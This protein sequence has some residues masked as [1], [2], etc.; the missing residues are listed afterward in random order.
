[1]QKSLENGLSDNKREMDQSFD[2]AL[3]KIEQFVD[4]A[5]CVRVLEKGFNDNRDEMESLFERV[6]RK[7]EQ[8]RVDND[9]TDLKRALEDSRMDASDHHGKLYRT[10]EDHSSRFDVL[11]QL[12]RDGNTD[13]DSSPVLQAIRQSISEIDLRALQKAIEAH[14]SETEDYFRQMANGIKANKTDLDISPHIAPVLQ[15][16]RDNR[17][18]VDV[19]SLQI[20]IEDHIDT[21]VERMLRDQKDGFDDVRRLIPQLLQQVKESDDLATKRLSTLASQN[22]R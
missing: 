13:I 14:R 11:Q 15:A 4:V 1:M 5:A 12:I 20:H 21:K 9:L 19:Q 16:I 18:H 6:Q 3:K 7:I 17:E 8:I 22:Y 10:L 2:R